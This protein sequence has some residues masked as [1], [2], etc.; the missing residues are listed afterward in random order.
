MIANCN[1]LQQGTP[2]GVNPESFTR[3]T[4]EQRMSW[5]RTGFESGDPNACNTFA[6]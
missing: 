3:G 5:F 6:G 2:G 1:R 4:S